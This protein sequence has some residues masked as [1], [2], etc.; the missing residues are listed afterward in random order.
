MRWCSGWD[1]TVAILNPSSASLESKRDG[2]YYRT[3]LRR[4][5][6]RLLKRA[7]GATLVIGAFSVCLWPHRKF[8]GMYP[9]SV[10][11][12][13]W[14]VSSISRMSISSIVV[15]GIAV[16][17][18]YNL[19]AGLLRAVGDSQAALWFWL[20]VVNAFLDIYS[21]QRRSTWRCGQRRLRD[22]YHAFTGRPSLLFIL[23]RASFWFKKWFRSDLS[24]Y[25][26]TYSAKA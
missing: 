17:F 6:H 1:T 25:T 2:R 18:A 23:K 4:N 9:P 3:L 16:T 7:V 12:N 26:W 20:A 8:S 21:L 10:P 15:I 5:N 19:C 22:D 13:T 11:W 14:R 24:N